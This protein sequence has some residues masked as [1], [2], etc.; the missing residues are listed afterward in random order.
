MQKKFGKI[1]RNRRPMIVKSRVAGR[2]SAA[3][4]RI[5]IALNSREN[6]E[7]LCSQLKA[8]GGSCVVLRDPV[9]RGT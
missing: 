3:S 8:A 7:K 2:G 9:T 1:L 4:H 6:A 5:R